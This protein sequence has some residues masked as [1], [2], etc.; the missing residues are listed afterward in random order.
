MA[1]EKYFPSREA[2]HKRLKELAK[3]VDK[4]LLEELTKSKLK[5]TIIE[6]FK[7]Q[8]EQKI[9]RVLPQL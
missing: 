4:H 2:V 5:D 9:Q 7:T 8:L 3:R 6:A 1:Y